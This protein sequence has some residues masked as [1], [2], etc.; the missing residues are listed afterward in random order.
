[1]TNGESDFRR[2]VLCHYA[3]VTD[4]D[5][6]AALANMSV[7]NFQRRFKAEFSCSAREWMLDRRAKSI[8]E[9]LRT[10]DKD[11]GTIAME[12]GF[13]TASYFSS[14][15]KNRL[16]ISPSELRRLNGAADRQSV[17][18]RGTPSRHPRKQNDL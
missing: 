10:T 8:L 18:V 15:C 9:E 1:M 16:G 14:F 11:L 7:R 4:V 3:K 6:F 5:E 12:H 2:F 13:S 17:P